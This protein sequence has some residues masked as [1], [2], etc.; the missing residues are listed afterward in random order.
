M[1]TNRFFGQKPKKRNGAGE[2]KYPTASDKATDW[3]TGKVQSAQDAVGRAGSRAM[4]AGRSLFGR[5]ARPAALPVDIVNDQNND[6]D[7]ESAEDMAARMLRQKEEYNS[8]GS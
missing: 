4:A 7:D 3:V 1:M 2:L 8:W 6:T 5:R